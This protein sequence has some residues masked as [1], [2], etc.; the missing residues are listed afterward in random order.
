MARLSSDPW[1]LRNSD[2]PARGARAEQLKFLVRYAT[3]APS[4]RNTQPWL[5]G[6]EHDQIIL[7]ADMSRWQPVA[8]PHKRDLYMSLGC[9]LENL[10]IALEHFGFGHLEN[11]FPRPDD[12][13][14]AAQI[15]ILDSP[16]VSSFR[17]AHLFKAI[18]QRHTNHGRYLKR[19]V[20]PDVIRKLVDCETDWNLTLLLTQDIGIKRA[21]DKLLL[22]ADAI[23]FSNPQYRDEL[24]ECIGRGNFGGPWL[25]SV[26]QQFAIAH[27][28][29][30]KT[31]A[32][33]GH[34]A[35]MS[36]PVF[37]L[38]SGQIV[39][40][41]EQLQAGAL[42]E[43]LYLTATPL[44]L[45][46]QPISQLLEIAEVKASFARLFRAGGV[47]L[48]PFRLGYADPAHPTPRRPLEEVLL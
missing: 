32:K 17:P 6:V 24:V 19:S 8:D 39:N 48:M 1:S 11:Y 46:L 22:K 21:V 35:L 43:R 37:G 4:S 26:A 38:I 30:K 12:D 14:V 36:S 18:T 31:V 2:F 5:F 42:L 15:A 13:S 27:L 33:G 10:L 45:C 34:A 40:R 23:A 28:G 29:V 44:G 9:A 47:P 25:L 3:L 16:S 7:H 20:T 41:E